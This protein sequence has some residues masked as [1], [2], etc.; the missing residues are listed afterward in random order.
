MNTAKVLISALIVV[1]LT[2]SGPALARG[3]SFVQAA[4]QL[5][6]AATK[7]HRAAHND[8]DSHRLNDLA[9]E[10][11][12]GAQRLHSGS[13]HGATHGSS[14]N[15]LHTIEHNFSELTR[16]YNRAHGSHH[17]RHLARHYAD[18]SHAMQR[19]R[20]A[21]RDNHGQRYGGNSY[22]NVERYDYSRSYS[23]RG[24]DYSRSRYSS[25]NQHKY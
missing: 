22:Y 9:H 5:E 10:I 8:G 21:N 12:R 16:I 14:D 19:M 24:H 23:R 7:F 4:H 6:N 18:L 15:R 3:N 13:E 25:R 11:A 20:A 2:S 17:V 1:G